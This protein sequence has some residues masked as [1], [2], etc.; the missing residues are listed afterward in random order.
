MGV[1]VGGV[2]VVVLVVVV[3]VVERIVTPPR[4]AAMLLGLSRRRGLEMLGPWLFGGRGELGIARE[5]G[6]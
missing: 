4:L 1:V 3:V 5:F 2:V 6:G